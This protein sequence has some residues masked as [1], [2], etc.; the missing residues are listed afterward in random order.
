[1]AILGAH[2]SIAG[3]CHR[4][5]ERANACGCQCVQLFTK[6]SNQWG[7]RPLAPDEMRQFRNALAELRITHPIAHDSYLINLG[8]PDCQLWEKSVAA[9]VDELHR[10]S[11]LGIPYVVAHPGAFTTGSE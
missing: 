5:V 3:G 8:S 2:Q 4:A 6:N 11:C 9:L 1:M 7:T 10:A